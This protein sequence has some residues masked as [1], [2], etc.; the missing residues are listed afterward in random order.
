MN[1]YLKGAATSL[2]IF[3]TQGS[4]PKTYSKYSDYEAFRSDWEKLS[5]DFK[6]SISEFLSESIHQNPEIIPR[7]YDHF[8]HVNDNLQH[9]FKKLSKIQSILIEKDET[10]ALNISEQLLA[11][12]NQDI[13][14]TEKIVKELNKKIQLINDRQNTRE[15]GLK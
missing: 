1:N 11:N 3:A 4:Q 15:K 9:I 2:D 10:L 14:L 13:N 12:L 6:F 8:K 7:L 5:D